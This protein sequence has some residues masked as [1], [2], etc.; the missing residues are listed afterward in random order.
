[1]IKYSL[2]SLLELDL[3]LFPTSFTETTSQPAFHNYQLVTS[4]QIKFFQLAEKHKDQLQRGWL[5][6][7]IM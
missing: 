5:W 6:K 1:M 4:V 3:E 2:C 7:N